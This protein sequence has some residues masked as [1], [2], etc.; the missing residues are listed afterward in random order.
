VHV[1]TAQIKAKSLSAR[2]KR[3][4]CGVSCARD[5]FVRETFVQ[6]ILHSSE[7]EAAVRVEATVEVSRLLSRCSR[8]P[9]RCQRLE[10]PSD[11]RFIG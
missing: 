5:V 2:Q 10:L 3:L 4:K 6:N 1:S 8:P 9:S 7:V 11:L